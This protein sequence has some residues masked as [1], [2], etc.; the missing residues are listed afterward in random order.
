MDFCEVTCVRMKI[1][2]LSFS[3]IRLPFRFAFRHSLAGR[4]SSLNIIAQAK[5]ETDDHKVIEGW[6]EGVPR[7]YVTGETAIEALRFLRSVC[8]T[9]FLNHEFGSTQDIIALLKEEFYQLGLDKKAFG[10]SW[11]ALELAILDGV[12][13]A[14]RLSYLDLLDPGKG[15][16]R[17]PGVTY[18]G[19]VP[20]SGA[21]ALR[22]VLW[23]Y[24]LYGFKTVKLKVGTNLDD[25]LS[26][27][28]MA[29]SILGKDIT[30]RVDANAAWNF[31]ETMRFAER[32]SKFNL[33]SIEQPVPAHDL[34]VLAKISSS[35]G[36]QV[37]ADESLC[38]IAQA[39]TLADERICTG[40]NIRLSKVG[41]FLAAAEIAGMAR[42]AGIACHLGAQVGESGILSAAGRAFAAS[43]GPFE[44]CEGSANFFLLKKDLTRENLTA[45]YGGFGKLLHAA[46]LGVTVLPERLKLLRVEEDAAAAKTGILP[47]ILMRC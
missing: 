21:K 3:M 30:L 20:F 9:R 22:A 4:S 17:C 15:L 44:N 25:D 31:E 24:R 10:A 33:A 12:A 23:F 32:A 34:K 8:A 26:R 18:G 6:G 29:R 5:I 7:D 35:I 2:S 27:V 36:E 11:C 19:V 37:I 13:K 1:T 45:G 41:G 39:Q 42:R 16:Y 28:R 47:D 46:G 14:Q 43:N 40:F 38:T